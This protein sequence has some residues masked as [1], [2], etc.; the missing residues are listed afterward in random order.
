MGRPAYALLNDSNVDWNQS[1]PEVRRF[2]EQQGLQ[3]IGVDEYG[4]S[5]VTVFVPQAHLWNCQA[6]TQE[7]AE[8]WIALSA[9]MILDGHDCTWLAPY[10]HQVLA[11]GS[12]Y[13]VRLPTHIPVAGSM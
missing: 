7:D 11:G 6:P 1:L 4:F 2:A 13:A 3:K 8:Q 12:V 9:N 10:P 5:D